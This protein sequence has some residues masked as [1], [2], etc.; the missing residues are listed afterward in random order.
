MARALES[1]PSMLSSRDDGLKY[2]Y[3]TRSYGL[4]DPCVRT[5]T[6]IRPRAPL[7]APARFEIHRRFSSPILRP[8]AKPYHLA[9]GVTFCFDTDALPAWLIGWRV[10]MPSFL[11]PGIAS[12]G[13]RTHLSTSLVTLILAGRVPTGKSARR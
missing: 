7:P 8:R 13:Q 2:L 9:V 3:R 6:R 10:S 4:R 12:I 5:A 11:S 1:G